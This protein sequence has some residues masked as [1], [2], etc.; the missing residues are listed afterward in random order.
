M[1]RKLLEA[2]QLNSS[3]ALTAVMGL[4]CANVIIAEG[5]GPLR[6]YELQG[7]RDAAFHVVTGK[8]PVRAVEP[9]YYPV[10]HRNLHLAAADTASV[11]DPLVLLGE[12]EFVIA[13]PSFDDLEII[14]PGA[15]HVLAVSD[16]VEEPLELAP[17]VTHESVRTDEVSAS[18]AP[19]SAENSA[20]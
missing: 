1:Q 15:S 13:A 10:R 12:P 17:P 18:A 9:A 4:F 11:D 19:Q 20:A 2:T 8:A 6:S 7:L 14:P 5:G 3:V 16:V